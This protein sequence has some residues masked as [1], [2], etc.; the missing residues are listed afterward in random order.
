MS[1]IEWKEETFQ[2]F[3]YNPDALQRCDFCGGGAIGL[4]NGL[5]VECKSL[6]LR[7]VK[8][9]QKYV[10]PFGD[11]WEWTAGLFDNGYGQFRVG[12]K[13]VKA[14]RFSFRVFKGRLLNTELACHECDNPRCVRPDHLFAGTE[15]DNSQD[16]EKKGRGVINFKPFFG[17]NNPASKLTPE[18]VKQIRKRR[19]TQNLSY[20]QLSKE[21]QIS[22]SQVANIIK[23]RSWKDV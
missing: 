4:R 13:K 8:R 20:S 19:A 17:V 5:C 11:C 18:K 22:E 23:N 12:K 3:S 16:R 15:K 9:F 2:E 14:H 1:K 7:L 6:F 21:F 10:T